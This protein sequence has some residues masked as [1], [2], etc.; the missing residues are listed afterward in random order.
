MNPTLD[1]AQ[2]FAEWRQ[3]TEAETLAITAHD[4]SGLAEVQHRK[5]D[6]QEALDIAE[7]APTATRSRPQHDAIRAAIDQLIRLE[8]SNHKLLTE[9]IAAMRTEKESLH[10]SAGNLRRLHRYSPSPDASAWQS[11]S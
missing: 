8:A 4:W 9:R 5:S 1:P 2:L 10:R 6:L 3:L 11:Y 7:H